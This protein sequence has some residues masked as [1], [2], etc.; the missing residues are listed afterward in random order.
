[1]INFYKLF[2]EKYKRNYKYLYNHPE[3]EKE[4]DLVG[5]ENFMRE[6]QEFVTGV[7]KVLFDCIASDREVRAF[8]MTGLQVC[9]FLTR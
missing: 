9:D 7:C 5:A 6:N 4:I 2:A 8:Y 3:K 1:M